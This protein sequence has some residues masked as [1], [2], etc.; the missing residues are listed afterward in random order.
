MW[1][2]TCTYH[3]CH[4][5]TRRRA[6]PTCRASLTLVSTTVSVPLPYGACCATSLSC[7][8][9]LE[10]RG[11]LSWPT[12]STVIWGQPDGSLLSGPLEAKGAAFASL[13]KHFH[14]WW[15]QLSFGATL[16]LR[17]GAGTGAPASSS[18][19]VPSSLS[20]EPSPPSSCGWLRLVCSACCGWR[21]C[22]RG[23][24]RGGCRCCC[25]DPAA[26]STT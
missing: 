2:S 24:R 21:G 8:A 14:I 5:G 22:C 26:A 11:S 6:A 19:D 13:Y 3:A 20:S 7:T 18:E 17:A 12:P 10:L 1:R 4:Y 15:R 16:R 25:W 9:C 23:D